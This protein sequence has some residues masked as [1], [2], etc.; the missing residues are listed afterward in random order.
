MDRGAWRATVHGVTES[1]MT[2]QLTLSLALHNALMVYL[3]NQ[4]LKDV[5][6]D[7]AIPEGEGLFDVSVPQQRVPSNILD[8]LILVSQYH[9]SVLEVLLSRTED[10]ETEDLASEEWS[11]ASLLLLSFLL[12]MWNSSP[13]FFLGNLVLSKMLSSQN[14]RCV[15]VLTYYLFINSHSL[16]LSLN[17]SV[18][19]LVLLF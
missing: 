18:L 9:W 3:M 8:I 6:A 12:E 2:E 7:G 11:L 19:C 5:G 13:K 17:A 16:S 14:I 4:F 15:C 1:D 10:W